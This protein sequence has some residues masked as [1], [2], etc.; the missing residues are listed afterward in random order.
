MA[1][2]TCF[3]LAGKIFLG[4]MGTDNDRFYVLPEETGMIILPNPARSITGGVIIRD[5][6]PSRNGTG[7]EFLDAPY[8]DVLEALSDCDD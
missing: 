4:L 6:F 8:E 7:P 1:M 2:V 5:A 3:V